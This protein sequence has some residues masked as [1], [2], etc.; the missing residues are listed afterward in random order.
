LIGRTTRTN[1]PDIAQAARDMMLES[2]AAGMAAVMRGM[3]DRP[4]SVPTLA[5]INVPT[6]VIFGDEDD[7]PISEG[8][9]IRKG[10]RNAEMRAVEKAGHYAPFEKPEEVSRILRDWLNNLPRT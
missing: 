6:L 8:E 3:A 5:T 7:L 9:A 10:I 1:R 4:D 2:S